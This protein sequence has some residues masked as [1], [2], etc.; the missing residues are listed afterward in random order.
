LPEKLQPPAENNR[1]L[2]Y[3][4][5][6]GMPLESDDGPRGF[7]LPQDADPKDSKTF[8]PMQVLHDTPIYQPW[9]PSSSP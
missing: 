5:G 8:L 6:H 3:F 2:F 9:L 7:L 4:A 1:L